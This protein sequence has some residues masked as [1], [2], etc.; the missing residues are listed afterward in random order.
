MVVATTQLFPTVGWFE[1]LLD[2]MN[3]DGEAF[4]KLGFIDARVGIAVLRDGAM[5]EDR[6]FMLTFGAY[7]CDGV[8]VLPSPEAAEVDFT[9]S[10]PYATWKEMIQNIAENQGADLRHTL[11][12]LH[13][14][15][16][17]L[18]AADQLRADLFFRI[19]ASLQRF[20]DGA[21]VIETR[22]IA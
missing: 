13:F 16:I 14:G 21:A 18:Q 19:N 17:D 2:V 4:R 1:A 7:T 12:H 20:F 11:N 9:L 6:A 8:V 22:F 5:P 15:R 3:R 10:A